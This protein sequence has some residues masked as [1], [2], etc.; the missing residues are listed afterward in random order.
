MN[1][2]VYR[3]V[4]LERLSSP[5]QLDSLMTVTRAKG[6]LALLG[7]SIIVLAAILWAFGG[8]IPT[9]VAGQGILLTGG[10][11]H[12]IVPRFPGHLND[13]RVV[14]GDIIHTGQTIARIAQPSLID[15]IIAAQGQLERL[16]RQL[17]ENSDQPDISANINKLEESI[18]RLRERH[19]L[20]S[21]VSSPFNARVVEVL[22]K[23][24]DFITRDEPLVK[25]ELVGDGV[26]ELVCFLFVAAQ[27]GQ[28]ILPGMDVQISPG[29]IKKE[30][31]GF[32]LGRVVAVSEHPA[33]FQRMMSV[34]ENEVLVQQ[35]LRA[36]ALTEVKVDLI[37]DLDTISGYRWSATQ[38]P[39]MLL[40][41]GT[42]SAGFVVV[43]RQRP[44]SLVIPGF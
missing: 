16:K 33:T 35:F 17:K 13:I 10:G 34:F 18:I 41:S 2:K 38:G 12:N 4:S 24:G 11:V 6:W 30:E 9:K 3:K 25:V 15:E 8:E 32:M 22:V 29:G 36:G 37:T 26:R 43:Q 7:I 20:T 42:L 44:I 23:R 31:Y 1:Y 5:E 14:E 40:S 28:R 19:D 21:R 39:A 27:E